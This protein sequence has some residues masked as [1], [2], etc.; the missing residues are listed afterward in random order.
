MA[1]RSSE[2]RRCS[3]CRRRFHPERSALDHQHVCGPECR[4]RRRR[5]L[6]RRRRER[7]LQV[8]REDER[9][10]QR[11]SRERRGAVRADSGHAPA[12]SPGHAPPGHA[13]AGPPGHAP[14]PQGPPSRSARTAHAAPRGPAVGA[15]PTSVRHAPASTPNLLDLQGK[16]AEIVDS[17]IALSR[18]TLE[19]E[20]PVILRKYLGESGTDGQPPPGLS[21]AGHFVQLPETQR[22]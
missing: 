9:E 17:V 6:A 1:G 12:V 4:R 3:E 10:R 8:W 18:A 2:T 13:P 16:A 11:R 7:A 15:P 5:R 14:P 21:R 19:R 20:L 22:E